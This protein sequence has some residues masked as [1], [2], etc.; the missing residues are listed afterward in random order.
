LMLSFAKVASENA[1]AIYAARQ[2][3]KEQILTVKE[4]PINWAADTTI[5]DSVSFKGHTASYKPS[6]VSGK[7]RLF[8]DRTKP[9]T[10]KVP[11][12]DHYKSS[13]T[14]QVPKAYIL[15]QGW[16]DVADRL[17]WN[18]VS[19]QEIKQDTVMDVEVYYIEN[20]ETIPHPY[21]KH[22]MHR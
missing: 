19:M 7:Q 11:F 3:D 4:M 8:Y 14:V 22:Y 15:K 1:T 16:Q 18:N 6:Q 2:A 21:E 9:Y 17:R 20:Y 12:Y 5:C 10:K 13:L